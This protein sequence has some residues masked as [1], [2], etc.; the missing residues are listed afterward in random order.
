MVLIFGTS[1]RLFGIKSDE[2]AGEYKFLLQMKD[3]KKLS[4][5]VFDDTFSYMA[6]KGRQSLPALFC[7]R[8]FQRGIPKNILNSDSIA[9]SVWCLRL[10]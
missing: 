7:L 6:H 3:R 4:M 8:P 2:E 9:V 5:T 1:Q 10:P